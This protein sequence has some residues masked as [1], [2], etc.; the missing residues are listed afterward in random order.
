M[1]WLCAIFQLVNRKFLSFF[2]NFYCLLFITSGKIW[3][4]FAGIWRGFFD[5]FSYWASDLQTLGKTKISVMI[6]YI[7][8]FAPIFSWLSNFFVDN[9]NIEGLECGSWKLNDFSVMWFDKKFRSCENPFKV[10]NFT[11]VFRRKN[12]I[13]P[14]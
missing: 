9:I 8:F 3:D 2:D 4:K 13:S 5:W 10:G 7:I 14:L 1:A 6:F 12:L 11:Q